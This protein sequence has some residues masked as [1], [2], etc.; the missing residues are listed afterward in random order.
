MRNILNTVAFDIQLH[1][2]QNILYKR[3][4]PTEP[5]AWDQRCLFCFLPMETS[6]AANTILTQNTGHNR[7]LNMQFLGLFCEI[8]CSQNK[9]IFLTGAN[10]YVFQWPEGLVGTFKSFLCQCVHS[11][12][13]DVKCAFA[14][15]LNEIWNLE[16]LK[17]ST[18]YHWV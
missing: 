9:I 1:P 8:H 17:P 5:P 6:W 14:L 7:G 2:Q 11:S 15:K 16:I 3:R 18:I 10:G 13:K 12:F 4:F